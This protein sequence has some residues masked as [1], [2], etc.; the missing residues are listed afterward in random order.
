MDKLITID[1][2]CIQE[3]ILL[4]VKLQALG[5][6]VWKEARFLGSEASVACNHGPTDS[7]VGSR[8]LGMFISPTISYLI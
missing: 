7:N 3:H 6:Q 5:H 1:I 8:G 4:G 2:I